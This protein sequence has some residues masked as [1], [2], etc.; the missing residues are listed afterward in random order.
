MYLISER[1]EGIN[2]IQLENKRLIKKIK[3]G[4]LEALMH[5][6]MERKHK[7]Y[8]IAWSYLYI[9]EDVEDVLQ[10]SMVKHFKILIPLR[11]Q[12]SLK[13]GLLPY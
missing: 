4:D 7:L 5:W 1:K 13:P 9:H 10:N 11:N 8:S 6:I 12:N 3:S 2:I